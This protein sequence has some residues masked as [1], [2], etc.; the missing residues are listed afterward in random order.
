MHMTSQRGTTAWGY[1]LSSE[2]FPPRELVEQAHR[3]EDAGFD[4]LTVSDHFHPWIEEQGHSPF[5]WT[6]IGGVAA[7]T[8][9]VNVGTGVT[10]PIMRYHPAIV[11]Q[12]AASAASILGGERFFLGVG[13][14]EL[15]NEHIIG[16]AWPPIEV[17]LD[18]LTEAVVVMRKLWTGE[19]VDHHGDH[20]TVDNARLFTVAD[21]D[22]P[23][24]WAA[25]GTESAKVAAHYADGLWST[26]PDPEVIDAYRSAGGLGPVYGQITVCYDRDVDTAV[27][28]ALR[29]WP[30]AGMPG[31]LAQDLPTWTHFES[32]AELVTAEHVTKRV[33]CGPDPDPI[34][35]VVEEYTKAGFDH[36]HFHQV[37]RDQQAFL[38][39]WSSTLLAAL[40]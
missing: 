38:N 16:D 10:C 23:V 37:G 33:P 19:T 2:E 17:R 26:S 30:N 1:T 15:L 6:T 36:I 32:V 25:S 31:Q 18:M 14:G 27:Q 7:R 21:Y 24:I 11:A 22:I 4:F 13:T 34:V 9:S 8:G 20:F 3:A 12:A 28:T 40:S 39:F 35:E 5:A 29:V